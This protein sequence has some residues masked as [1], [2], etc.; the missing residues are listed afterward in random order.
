MKNSE[1]PNFL[2]ALTLSSGNNKNSEN[3][4][5]DVK[6]G[7]LLVL[8][9]CGCLLD[10]VSVEVGSSALSQVSGRWV[11]QRAGG[12]ARRHINGADG[13]LR[14]NYYESTQRSGKL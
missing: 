8:G 6:Q 1:L 3:K 12:G 4:R 10:A 2:K 9:F 7:I 14:T 13:P 11:L 5:N